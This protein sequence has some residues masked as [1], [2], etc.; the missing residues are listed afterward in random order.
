[1]I[2]WF[3]HNSTMVEIYSNTLTGRSTPSIAQGVS[4]SRPRREAGSPWLGTVD[5]KE[6]GTGAARK[7]PYGVFDQRI[8]CVQ[9]NSAKACRPDR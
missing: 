2:L 4:L 1:M 3:P 8:I 7:P 5:S 9:R 6:A